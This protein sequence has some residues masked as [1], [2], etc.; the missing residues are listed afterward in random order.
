[1]VDTV[2]QSPFEHGNS[3]VSA[4]R[5]ILG[6]FGPDFLILSRELESLCQLGTI[7]DAQSDFGSKKRQ[8][9]SGNDSL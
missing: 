4:K 2:P 8:E 6:S 3:V 9:V 7:P 5:L 1:M